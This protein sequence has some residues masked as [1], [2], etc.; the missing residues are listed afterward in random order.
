MTLGPPD[1]FLLENM[2]N[3]KIRA[4][5]SS[6]ELLTSRDD[7]GRGFGLRGAELKTKFPTSHRARHSAHT[8]TETY[9][10]EA[11]TIHW[12]RRCHRLSVVR[13]NLRSMPRTQL[14][15]LSRSL[16]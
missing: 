3:L 6:H 14:Q 8:E 10:E 12:D 2:P 1:T 5:T 16:D 13:K 7:P 11:S 4:L 9:C 15:Y